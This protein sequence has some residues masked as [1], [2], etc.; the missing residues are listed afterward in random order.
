MQATGSDNRYPREE[1]CLGNIN[2]LQIQREAGRPDLENGP[3]S[4]ELHPALQIPR[5]LDIKDLDHGHM[6]G[7]PAYQ[8]L[9]PLKYLSW[10]SISCTE[11]HGDGSLLDSFHLMVA[12]V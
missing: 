1:I 3:E 2:G 12:P 4:R 7:S 10:E 6:A 5:G 9:A 8:M 11:V